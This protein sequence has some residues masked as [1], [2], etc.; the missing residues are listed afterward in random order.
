MISLSSTVFLACAFQCCV[1]LRASASLT[2]IL[3]FPIHVPCLLA[4]PDRLNVARIEEEVIGLQVIY[5]VTTNLNRD[6]VPDIQLDVSL[7]IPLHQR[8]DP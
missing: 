2:V 1:V 4:L 5:R 7:S 6:T 3:I 8:P